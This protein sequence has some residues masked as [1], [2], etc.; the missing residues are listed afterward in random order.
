MGKRPLSKQ[1]RDNRAN[2]LNPAHP[3]YHRTRGVTLDEAERQ[4]ERARAAQR[5]ESQLDGG[6]MSRRRKT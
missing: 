5:L 2:Q 3:L 1:A 6:A 4:A